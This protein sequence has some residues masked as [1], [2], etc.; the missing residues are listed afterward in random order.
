[1]ILYH[2]LLLFLHQ[3]HHY[4]QVIAVAVKPSA[5]CLGTQRSTL[6]LTFLLDEV[7]AAEDVVLPELQRTVV[8]VLTIPVQEIRRDDNLVEEI[9]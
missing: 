7:I 6:I 2:F 8:L 4:R 1:M 5:A 9:P 3:V